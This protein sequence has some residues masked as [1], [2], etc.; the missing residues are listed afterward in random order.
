MRRHNWEDAFLQEDA[1]RTAREAGEQLRREARGLGGAAGGEPSPRGDGAGPS[2]AEGGVASPTAEFGRGRRPSGGTRVPGRA[3]AADG[4]HAAG[5]PVY[6]I[7]SDSDLE[8][9]D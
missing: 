1:E 8:P 6:M 3:P 7:Y 2:S 4:G 9:D 5:S